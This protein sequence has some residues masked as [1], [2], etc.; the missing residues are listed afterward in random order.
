MREFYTADLIGYLHLLENQWC[1]SPPELDDVEAREEMRST[2]NCLE[3]FLVNLDLYASWQTL[4]KIDYRQTPP[5]EISRLSLELRGRL[6]DEL[7]GQFFFYLT[8]KEA[9]RWKDTQPFGGEVF[10]HFP[11]AIIE[12]EEASKCLALERSTA[13]VFHLMRA[14]EVAL[15]A[16]AGELGV[17]YAPSWEPYLKQIQDRIDQK[18]RKKGIKWKRDEPFFRDVLGHLQAVKVAWRNPTMHVINQYTLEQAEDIFNTVRVFMRH[19]ATKLSENPTK[20]ASRGK[21]TA[22]PEGGA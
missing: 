15:K 8:R 22:K 13:A 2:L 17:A 21:K 1:L 5:G 3:R 20:N 7:Q 19:L 16:T 11:S 6:V 9:I 18:W 10:E 14:M 12:I 4:Q